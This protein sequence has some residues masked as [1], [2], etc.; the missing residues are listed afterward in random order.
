MCSGAV[1]PRACTNSARAAG[2]CGNGPRIAPTGLVHTHARAVHAQS[3]QKRA[4]T[5]PGAGCTRR[6]RGENTHLHCVEAIQAQVIHKVCRGRHLRGVHLLKVLHHGDDS[7]RHLLLVEEGLREEEE[8]RAREHAPRE[9][10]TTAGVRVRERAHTVK[11]ARRAHCPRAHAQERAEAPEPV[12][13]RGLR[14]RT[15]VPG[16]RGGRAK[17]RA[18][19]CAQCG[20][21]QRRRAG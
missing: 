21:P 4:R 20:A 2:R 14:S 19:R 16:G 5:P 8:G 13:R 12:Q 1:R 10:R 15:P 18:A 9:G 6:G 17:R 11:L 3:F 7:F